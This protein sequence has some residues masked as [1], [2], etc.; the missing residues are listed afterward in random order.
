A[1]GVTSGRLITPFEPGTHNPA[2]LKAILALDRAI[3]WAPSD[4]SREERE[5][6][7]AH[8]SA[9]NECTF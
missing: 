2:A 4:L 6:I 3:R 1:V 8:V 5:M 9:V 7:A